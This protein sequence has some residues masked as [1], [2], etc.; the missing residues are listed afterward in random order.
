MR[1]VGCRWCLYFNL[2]SYFITKNTVMKL[3]KILEKLLSE[4]E[5]QQLVG[6]YDVVGDIAIT[7]IPEA[8]ENRESLIGRAILESNRKI[9]V[10][11]KRAG[12]Y[13]GEFRTIPLDIIAGE[14]RKETEV[15]EFGLR[16]KVNP[17]TVYYSVRSGNERKRVATCVKKGE[18]V[19]VLFSGV[20][21]YPLVISKYSEAHK[22]VG[23]EKN[24]I[25]HS[26]AM[27]NLQKNK[28]LGNIELL[29]GDVK[30]LLPKFTTQFDRVIMP[31]PTNG[32]KFLDDAI[33]VLKPEGYLH[34]YDLQQQYQF[35]QT[36]DKISAACAAAKRQ[37]VHAEVTRC[38]H[39][40]PRTYR[41]CVDARI[42]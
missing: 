25:A 29:N 8:L 1:H 33:G 12:L 39:C 41:I 14:E 19:L 4:K 22:I 9:K 3:K 10:V 5:L 18:F 36:V 6:G 32:E 24:P 26:Y 21:P 17:E 40:A 31:L 38:G 37:L 23:I 35:Q 11:A 13:G 42:Y 2:A 16:L 34:F 15:K 30:I 27:Q 28:K 7:I 20:A